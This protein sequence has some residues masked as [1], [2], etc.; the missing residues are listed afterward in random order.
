MSANCLITVICSTYNRPDALVAT[1]SGLL[2]QNDQNFEV[3]V[4]DDGSTE[5]TRN[6]VSDFIQKA[7][8]RVFHAWHED[9]GFRLAAI[10]NL[11][12]KYALA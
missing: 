8:F 11:A 10:R 6:V 3:I 12:L 9:L 7:S 2:R 4:A 1:L 5:N